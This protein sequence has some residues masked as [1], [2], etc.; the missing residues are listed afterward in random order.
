MTKLGTKK[1]PVRF[2]VQTEGRLHEIASLCD[3]NGWIFVGGLEPDKPED[4]CEV[5]YLLNPQVF[6]SQPRETNSIY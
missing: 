5:E 2:R 6:T 3:K 4:L 1:K